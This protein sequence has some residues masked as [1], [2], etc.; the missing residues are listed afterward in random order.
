MKKGSGAVRRSIYL[1]ADYEEVGQAGSIPRILYVALE[2]K[3]FGTSEPWP[4]GVKSYSEVRYSFVHFPC[5]PRRPELG[6]HGCVIIQN[7]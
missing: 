2:S 3:A 1:P 7:K 6:D 4:K 5:G